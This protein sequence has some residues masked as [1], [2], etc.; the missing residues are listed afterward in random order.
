MTNISIVDAALD[1]LDEGEPKLDRQTRRRLKL[2][3]RAERRV[4]KVRPWWYQVD[5]NDDETA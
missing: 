1:D 2:R 3:T 5:D 4:I